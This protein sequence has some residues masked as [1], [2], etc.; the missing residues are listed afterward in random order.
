MNNVHLRQ[1]ED[2]LKRIVELESIC[3]REHANGHWVA[4]KLLHQSHLLILLQ[5]L[6]F[7]LLAKPPAEY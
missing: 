6:P 5:S 1:L 3:R 7:Q 4:Q 2:D